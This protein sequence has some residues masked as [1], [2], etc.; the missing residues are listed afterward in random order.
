MHIAQLEDE[1]SNSELV[2][3]RKYYRPI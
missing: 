1:Q 3:S 2:W